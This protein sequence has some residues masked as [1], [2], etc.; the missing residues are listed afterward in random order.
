MRVW[1]GRRTGRKSKPSARTSIRRCAVWTQKPK[2]TRPARDLT[3]LSYL[4][5]VALACHHFV[6]N[7][8][9]KES[10][11]QAGKQSGLDP[12]AHLKRMGGD[13]R[14]GLGFMPAP[15]G[16]VQQEHHN[17]NAA[18]SADDGRACW[19]IPGDG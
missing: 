12:I 9:Y 14:H 17:Q 18:E 5:D 2:R 10:D 7:R 19:E 16:E 11:Q 4:Q 15:E 13:A 1:S 6:K 3:S 8:I